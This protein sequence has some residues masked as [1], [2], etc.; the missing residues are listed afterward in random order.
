[1][2]GISKRGF[3]KKDFMVRYTTGDKKRI[4]GNP[5]MLKQRIKG[6]GERVSL[7]TK[8]SGVL[9]INIKVDRARAEEI[10]QQIDTKQYSARAWIKA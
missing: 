5:Y 9:E 3:T 6:E 4:W 8:A 10:K 2:S 1:M 7:L